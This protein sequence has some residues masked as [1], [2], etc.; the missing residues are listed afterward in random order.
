MD[1]DIFRF[2]DKTIKKGG[3]TILC[4]I[5][6]VT[7][8][9]FSDGGKFFGVDKAV[10]RALELIDEG[11]GMID[12][13]G[14]STRP[15]STYVDIEEEINR[16][17]PVIR[18]LKEM[19]NIPISIDTWK[20]DV[21][22]KAIEN[23]ADIVN[24]ITGFLGDSKMAEVVSKTDAGAILMFNPVLARPNH[25]SSKKFPKFG[26]DWIFSN[27]ELKSFEN[28]EIVELMKKYFEKSI[29]LCNKYGINKDRIML[30]PGIGFGLTKKENLKLVDEIDVIKDMGYFTF[31][32][33]SR[34]RFIVNLLNDN[35]I[36]S[37]AETNL[38]FENRDEAS[39]AL[40]TI[41]AYKGVEVL[42]VHT[43]KHHK[44]AKI[45]G[46]AIRMNA[47]L[48]DINFDAYR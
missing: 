37:S 17:V 13:G 10:K 29:S 15:G 44:I 46:D 27:E 11:A 14:E 20:A 39:S 34:K 6:N 26:G 45:V 12:I 38:G 22:E 41:G 40:T 9:S 24:D 35:G 21:A 32:G 2:K 18:K 31:L 4:G 33:V 16:V 25:E 23:G 48:K 28:M 3:E 42:R 8:D 19:T 36:D 47:S 1:T 30:D 43:V 5:V 7:P